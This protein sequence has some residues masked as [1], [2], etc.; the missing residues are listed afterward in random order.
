MASKKSLA[1]LAD[2][3]RG[4][5]KSQMESG[6]RFV[7]DGIVVGEDGMFRVVEEKADEKEKKLFARKAKSYDKKKAEEEKDK[8]KFADIEALAKK[9]QE[10]EAAQASESQAENAARVERLDRK[11]EVREESRKEEKK[12]DDKKTEK[13]RKESIGLLRMI[14]RGAGGV[15][16][17]GVQVADEGLSTVSP[18]YGAARKIPA[19]AGNAVGGVL[20]ALSMVFPTLLAARGAAGAVGNVLSPL[21][22]GWQEGRNYQDERK[23]H[24]TEHW[25]NRKEK[26]ER[27]DEEDQTPIEDG[28]DETLDYLKKIYEVLAKGDT[29][30]EHSQRIESRERRER[31]EKE[32]EEKHDAPVQ[33][34]HETLRR[35]GHLLHNL[36]DMAQIGGAFGG[37]RRGGRNL[38]RRLFQLLG[39]GAVVAAIGPVVSALA[40]VGSAFAGVGAAISLVL[41]GGAALIG[42]MNTVGTGIISLATSVGNFFTRIGGGIARFFSG[43]ANNPIIRRIIGPI[44]GIIGLEELN[45]RIDGLQD[46]QEELDQLFDSYDNAYRRRWARNEMERFNN[47]VEYSERQYGRNSP[48]AVRERNTRLRFYEE[49]RSYLEE[50]PGM[51]A[52]DD[53]FVPLMPEA[54]APHAPMAAAGGIDHSPETAVNTS[55]PQEGRALLDTIASTESPGYNVNYGGGLFHSYADHPRNP[56]PITSGPH[57]GNV[58][59]AAGRYQFIQDTWD[60]IAAELGLTDFSPANQDIAAWHLAQQTYNTRTGRDLL[61]DLRSGDESRRSQIA[62][63]LAATWTS[64]PSGIEAASG[65]QSRFSNTYQSSLQRI[66]S[67]TAAS[68][69]AAMDSSQALMT[70]MDRASAAR[71]TTPIMNSTSRGGTTVNN[72]TVVNTTSQATDPS[73]MT[74]TNL[75]HSKGLVQ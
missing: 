20:D 67:S 53:A 7:G 51:P 69:Q 4:A 52:P 24:W 17:K 57:R 11:E 55:I 25:K 74:Q 30:D 35:R 54:F 32:R 42:V 68:R 9:E 41:G 19:V 59:S 27:E 23:K 16:W 28:D 64:L 33:Q 62:R 61:A 22:E 46:G 13:H 40:G 66:Q 14:A 43:I 63:T 18:L 37:R 6:D 3:I 8:P 71:I 2:Q 10:E 58:S 31:V 21:K 60:G 73:I 50:E 34:A 65:G 75:I 1:S 70:H 26:F 15:A 36:S 48:E 38:G 72:N 45:N 47:S 12:K 29:R 5:N 49:H 39:F 44:G 56:V